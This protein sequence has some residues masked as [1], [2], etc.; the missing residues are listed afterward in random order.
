[1]NVRQSNV[2]IQVDSPATQSLGTIVSIPFE[3]YQKDR[4]TQKDL[5]I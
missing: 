2:A 3:P 1:M 4:L 5:Q